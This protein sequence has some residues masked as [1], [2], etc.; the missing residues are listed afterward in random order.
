MTLLLLTT[1]ERI[2]KPLDGRVSEDGRDY[3]LSGRLRAQI[4]G[5]VADK[6]RN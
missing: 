1:C 3:V 5:S 4:R 2:Q 6:Q